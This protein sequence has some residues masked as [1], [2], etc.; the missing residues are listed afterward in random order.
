MQK[1]TFFLLLCTGILNAQ[2][3]F[4]KAV[5]DFVKKPSLNHA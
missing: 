4:Q 5:D 1:F 2:N 3:T